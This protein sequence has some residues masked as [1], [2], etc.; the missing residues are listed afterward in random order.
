MCCSEPL[1]TAL[2]VVPFYGPY[3]LTSQ[4]GATQT[5]LGERI[6]EGLLKNRIGSF[7]AYGT[8]YSSFLYIALT[9]GLVLVFM[10]WRVHGAP[11]LQRVAGVGSGR[12][13]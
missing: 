4:V 8:F 9:G 5:Y 2:V 10:A 1:C 13:R 7:L 3:L 11:A 12:Q 6:G